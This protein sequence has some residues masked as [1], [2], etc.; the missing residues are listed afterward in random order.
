MT[1]TQKNWPRKL[2]GLP[3]LEYL[4][5][6]EVIMNLGRAVDRVGTQIVGGGGSLSEEDVY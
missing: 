6:R 5:K 4:V 3:L 1:D 2:L